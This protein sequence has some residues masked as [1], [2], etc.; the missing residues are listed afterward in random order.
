MLS[1]RFLLSLIILA[2]LIYIIFLGA[3]FFL[4]GKPYLEE[5]PIIRIGLLVL[6]FLFLGIIMY[7]RIRDIIIWNSGRKNKGIEPRVTRAEKKHFKDAIERRD[8]GTLWKIAQDFQERW[9]VEEYLQIL[10]TITMYDPDGL[11]GRKAKKILSEF[12]S[13]KPFDKQQLRDIK[14]ASAKLDQNLEDYD[15]WLQLA[16]VH[17]KAGL[18]KD[19]REIYTRTIEHCENSNLREYAKKRLDELEKK[20]KS[21]NNLS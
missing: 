2:V 4:K 5:N 9:L 21:D 11:Y 7:F 12:D 3:S 6:L 8:V 19:A 1:K 17:A 13:A 16:D 15:A 14:R 10:R 20:E 18:Y